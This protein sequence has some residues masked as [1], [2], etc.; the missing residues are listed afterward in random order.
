M[1]RRSRIAFI[2]YINQDETAVKVCFER[3]EH[4][5]SLTHAASYGVRKLQGA[6]KERPQRNRNGCAM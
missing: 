5:L 2:T 4:G 3:S 1:L 6:T